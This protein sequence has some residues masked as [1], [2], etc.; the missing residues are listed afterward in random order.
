MWISV[1]G[2]IDLKGILLS[3]TKK[4]YIS[5]FAYLGEKS[6]SEMIKNSQETG[7]SVSLQTVII[8]MDQLSSRQFCY[9]PGKAAVELINVT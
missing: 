7:R 1:Y 2:R 3:V 4:D 8:D 9:K 6:M 5:Y